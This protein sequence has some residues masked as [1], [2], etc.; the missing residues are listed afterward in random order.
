MIK[1]NVFS[2]TCFLVKCDPFFPLC[3]SQV[4]TCEAVGPKAAQGHLKE[5]E[6]EQERPHRVS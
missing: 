2:I 6:E 5:D 3:L 4:C 1:K